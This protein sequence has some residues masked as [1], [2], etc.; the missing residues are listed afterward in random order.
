[1]KIDAAD[2]HDVLSAIAAVVVVV[3][4]VNVSSNVLLNSVLPLLFPSPPHLSCLLCR[5]HSSPVLPSY[6]PAPFLKPL[7]QVTG[8]PDD[9]CRGLKRKSGDGENRTGKIDF[10]DG[11]EH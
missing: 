4:V 11:E 3:V 5:S 7:A 9:T 10:K 8:A 2:D 6:M 1:M